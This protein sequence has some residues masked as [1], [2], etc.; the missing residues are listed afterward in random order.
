MNALLILYNNL[1]KTDYYSIRYTIFTKKNLCSLLKKYFQSDLFLLY[2][3]NGFL[4]FIEL[5]E[6]TIKNNILGRNVFT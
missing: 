6:I 4:I 5:C 2:F 3:V 1:K